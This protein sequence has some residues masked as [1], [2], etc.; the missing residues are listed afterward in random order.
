M[1]TRFALASRRRVG[2][3]VEEAAGVE[4]EAAAGHVYLVK[5]VELPALLISS[6]F[7]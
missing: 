4:E 1:E 6:A 5:L 7:L 3:G 2:A